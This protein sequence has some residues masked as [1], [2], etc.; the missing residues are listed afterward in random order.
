MASTMLQLIQQATGEM[1][2]SIPSAVAG[3]S[4]QDTVQCLALLNAVGY[5]L[6][7]EFAWQC[8]TKEYRFT[9][10]FLATT[11]TWTTAAATVTAIPTTAALSGGTWMAMGTGIPQDCYILTVDGPH[12]VTLSQTPNAAGTTATITFCQSKYAMPTDFDR[13][14]D[15]TDW[16]KSK[17]WEML[18]PSTPQQWQWLKSG[19]ISTGPRLRFRPLGGYFQVWPML[20]TNEY[21]GFEY[22]SN[23]W[24]LSAAA[25]ALGPTADKASFTVDTDTCVFP[26]RLM[27]LG[28]KLKYFQVKG[29]DAGAFAAAYQAQLSTSKAEDAGAP[30]LSMAPRIS[31]VLIGWENIPDSNYGT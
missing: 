20:G 5:E 4:A 25:Q 19:Y 11:G 29:F 10:Q 17:H 31:Q 3:N 1:G 24:V 9:T 21:L 26:D 8:I 7:R 15:R 28:L 12:Q 13:L 6:Q 27:V 16:D 22:V 2:I 30:T 14:I 18:G 23:Q